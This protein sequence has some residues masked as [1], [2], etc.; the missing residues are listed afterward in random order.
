MHSNHMVAQFDINAKFDE[1]AIILQHL[2]AL[3]EP[4]L[5]HVNEKM[6]LKRVVM[7]FFFV[8]GGR[9]DNYLY[10]WGVGPT[11]FSQK[12]VGYIACVVEML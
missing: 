12:I 1:D 8:S 7:K 6:I 9:L 3:E 2:K 4:V 5:L 11:I 10:F